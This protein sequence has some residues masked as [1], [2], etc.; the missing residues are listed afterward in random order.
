MCT[1]G[2]VD[3][4]HGDSAGPIAQIAKLIEDG[5]DAQAI[6]DRA[7]AARTGDNVTAVLWRAE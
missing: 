6:V 5:A 1:D 2:A 3:P 7:L 4:G